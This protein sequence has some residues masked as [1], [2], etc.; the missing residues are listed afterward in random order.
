MGIPV[1]P[2]ASSTQFVISEAQRAFLGTKGLGFLSCFAWGQQSEGCRP[3]ALVR[4]RGAGALLSLVTYFYT[5]S[6]LD[7]I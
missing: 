4:Y 5:F 3:T 7:C 1:T 2:V 6:P